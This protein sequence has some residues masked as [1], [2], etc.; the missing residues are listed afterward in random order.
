MK[1][2][3]LTVFGTVI[4]SCIVFNSSGQKLSGCYESAGKHLLNFSSDSTVQVNLLGPGCIRASYIAF[5]L[6]KIKNNYLI[7]LVEKERRNMNPIWDCSNE[8]IPLESSGYDYI[9]K[10]RLKWKLIKLEDDTFSLKLKYNNIV[11]K[12][13]EVFIRK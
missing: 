4:F 5:G 1:L 3:L 11:P 9:S 7:I 12:R 10:K 8:P 6:Y 2:R 13:V